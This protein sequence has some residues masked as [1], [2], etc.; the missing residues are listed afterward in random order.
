MS[1]EKLT[2][3][4]EN[5]CNGRWI[6]LVRDF[7]E[8]GDQ[9]ATATRRQRRRGDDVESRAARFLFVT[10]LGK[11][12]LRGRPCWQVWL[13]LREESKFSHT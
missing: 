9:A 5:F 13:R 12:S 6:D 1:K 7:E 11:L 8:I 3:R 4:L 2:E 10:Q